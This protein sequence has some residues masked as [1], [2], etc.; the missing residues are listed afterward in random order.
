[1]IAVFPGPNFFSTTRPKMKRAIMFPMRCVAFAWRN[2]AVISVYALIEKR[3][4]G[5]MTNRSKISG[6]MKSS[7]L[8][9]AMFKRMIVMM[10]LA[11]K[12]NFKVSVNGRNNS[13][14]GFFFRRT[15]MSVTG[16]RM[17]RSKSFQ[18]NR[19]SVVIAM[20]RCVLR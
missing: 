5:C 15:W 11:S 18:I 17:I 4:C 12:R 8:N 10:N 9:M 1:M 7:I 2:P 6:G 14:A 13:F 3:S 19:D 16:V 20:S